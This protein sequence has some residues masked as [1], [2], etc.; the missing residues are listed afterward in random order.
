MNK[1]QLTCFFLKVNLDQ[2]ATETQTANIVICILNSAFSLITCMG[3]FVVLYVIWKTQELHSPSF[4]LLSCLAAADL[5]VG[6]VCQPFFVAYKM[7]ELANNLSVYCTMRMMYNI[8]SWTTTAVSLVTLSLVSVHQLLALTL[9]LRYN[10]IVTVP[11]VLQISACVW[12]L[13]MMG[14]TSRFYIKNWLAI[15][16]VTLLLTFLVTTLSTLKIFQIVRKHQR[17]ITQQQQSVQSNTINVLKCRKA[18]VTVIYVYGLFVVFYLPFHAMIFV[19]KFSGYTLTV[20]I[21]YDFAATVV[22]INSFLNPFV[23]CW[24]FGE[25]RRAVKRTLRKNWV[26]S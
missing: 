4:I 17:Q 26:S 21:A 5:L 2:T 20:K 12:I 25:I 9:H 6:L 16:V 7:A 11:R 24:R 22:F 8:P 23:L 10:T 14:I 19:E 15:P 1:T 13:S 18:A 3:N